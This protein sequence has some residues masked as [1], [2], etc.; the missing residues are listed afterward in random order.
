MA[1]PMLAPFPGA[2]RQQLIFLL[3]NSLFATAAFLMF[4]FISTLATINFHLAS[5]PWPP[6]SYICYCYCF[7]I[8][9]SL[10]DS[11]AKVIRGI[12][13]PNAIWFLSWLL[14]ICMH[15]HVAGHKLSTGYLN[16]SGLLQG[17][18]MDHKILFLAP[19]TCGIIKDSISGSVEFC[20][21][22]SE[23]FHKPWVLKIFLR[24][25]L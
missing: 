3:T 25:R 11:M 20:L 8:E 19:W 10:G 9:L 16:R 22:S 13:F 12:V 18:V 4:S 5:L 1:F 24:N 14:C 6:C 2:P 7:H 17:A 15:L 23:S 21:V